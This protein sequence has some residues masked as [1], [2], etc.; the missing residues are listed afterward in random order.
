MRIALDVSPLVRNRAGIGTYVAHLLT[1]LVAFNAWL[2]AGCL[3]P[4]LTAD[5]PEYLLL[6][7]RPAVLLGWWLVSFI[8]ALRL[9][10]VWAY[11]TVEFGR[12][13]EITQRSQNCTSRGSPYFA[14]RRSPVSVTARI[15]LFVCLG[16]L[17]GCDPLSRLRPRSPA[18][19]QRGMP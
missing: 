1:S 16:W 3:V 13:L 2:I 12:W 14:S 8:V 9:P 4:Y 18:R 6:L 5:E 19:R 15:R 17:L 11:S 7:P 10:A